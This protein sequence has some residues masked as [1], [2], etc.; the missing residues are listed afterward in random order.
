MIESNKS[1]VLRFDDRFE[2]GSCEHFFHFMWG[3]LL[4]SVYIISSRTRPGNQYIFMTCGPLMDPI[5]QEALSSLG[6]NCSILT[7]LPSGNDYNVIWVSRWDMYML[8]PM[9]ES[10]Y[11]DNLVIKNLLKQLEI[12]S[13]IAKELSSF[14]LK[15]AIWR[16]KFILLFKFKLEHEI[17]VYVGNEILILKRSAEPEFYNKDTGSAVIKGY[18]MSRRGI[19][20]PE[21][22]AE[23]LHN[24]G[25][26]VAIFEPGIVSFKQQIVAFSQCRGVFAMRGAEFANMIWLKPGAKVTLIQPE[27]L[28]NPP[29]Q[30]FLAELLDLEYR[31]VDVTSSYPELDREQIL[32]G[33]Q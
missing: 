12:H 32:S 29:F 26:A 7:Q 5:L 19:K 11:T 27:S 13:D 20:N 25:I 10:K 18:G 21:F 9:L 33:V 1:I 8:K 2:L 24:L 28:K 23:V 17:N 3:Y 16:V 4:P 15:S 14:N 30:R 22:I 6:V 31:Q